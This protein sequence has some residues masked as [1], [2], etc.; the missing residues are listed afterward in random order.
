VAN[1]TKPTE[2]R[3]PRPDFPRF[4]QE[5]KRWAKKIWG[6]RH[7]LVPLSDPDAALATYLDQR[8]AL[9]GGR[10]PRAPEDGVTVKHS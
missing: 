8:D 2:P 7:Y 5:T 9:H 10:T 3:R 4:A 1:S 6:R